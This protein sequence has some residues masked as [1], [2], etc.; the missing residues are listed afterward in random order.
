MADTPSFSKHKEARELKKQLRKLLKKQRLKAFRE[1]LVG[2][3]NILVDLPSE[4]ITTQQ[5]AQNMND[6]IVDILKCLRE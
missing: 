1:E 2:D 5:R 6:K 3:G 4:T